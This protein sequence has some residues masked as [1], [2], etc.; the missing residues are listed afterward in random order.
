MWS[1]GV[2]IEQRC[3]QMHGPVCGTL[4]CARSRVGQGSA[5]SAE[6]L[7]LHIQCSA[8][9]RLRVGHV[10]RDVSHLCSQ[11]TFF[12][13][14]C[15]E[16]HRDWSCGSFLQRCG[17]G[18]CS[19]GGVTAQVT[20]C[21]GG[22][23]AA[24]AQQ[25]VFP[26]FAPHFVLVEQE[27]GL[28]CPRG[29]GWSCRNATHLLFFRG[30]RKTDGTGVVLGRRGVFPEASSLVISLS[31]SHSLCV[32]HQPRCLAEPPRWNWQ[33]VLSTRGRCFPGSR[34]LEF[35]SGMTVEGFRDHEHE[36]L[37]SEMP[38]QVRS[39]RRK[40]TSCWPAGLC[41]KCHSAAL[42]PIPMLHNPHALLG[43]VSATK[44]MKETLA[45]GLG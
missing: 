3:I 34:R 17:Q 9:P 20:S 22:G 10:V 44:L 29:C 23:A 33:Q 7:C 18:S 36:L 19:S 15:L 4:V 40:K 24:F 6:V 14:D 2:F 45:H 31:L 43:K 13:T 16:T 27:Q 5:R 42:L 25:A 21:T 35:C 41:A 11:Q 37:C 1:A 38:L 8:S 26:W 28:P 32:G 30:S 12:S 39:A